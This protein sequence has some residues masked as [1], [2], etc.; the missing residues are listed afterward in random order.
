MAVCC[1]AKKGDTRRR[2]TGS[3]CAT[4]TPNG[5]IIAPCGFDL[6]RTLRE[7]AGARSTAGLV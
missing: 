3:R 2:S 4:P 7:A 5:L 6:D 1:W